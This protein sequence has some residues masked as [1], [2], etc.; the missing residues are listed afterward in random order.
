MSYLGPFESSADSELPK[1]AKYKGPKNLQVV[2]ET[3]IVVKIKHQHLKLVTH[4]VF[5]NS[6]VS[7]VKF[8][9]SLKMAVVLTNMQVISPC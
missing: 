9:R 1:C 7:T 3:L 5:L 4:L 6:Q 2:L 8:S